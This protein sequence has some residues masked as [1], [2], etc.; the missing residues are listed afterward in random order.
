MI[1]ELVAD[2]GRLNLLHGLA[3][4]R[5]GEVGHADLARQ[6]LLAELDEL[7]QGGR[8]IHSRRGPMDQIEI[9][10]G[11]LQLR[12]RG[13]HGALHGVGG[14]IFPPDLGGQV[15][16]AARHGGGGQRRP[17]AVFIAIHLGGVDVPVAAGQ[18]ALHSRLTLR[19]LQSPGAEPEL[20]HVQPACRDHRVRTHAACSIKAGF[21]EF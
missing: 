21:G 15:N 2:D 1:L 12:E 5:N 9:D 4:Q 3:Q 7:A 8:K 6:P 13:L 10:I 14:E 11:G 20:G 18:R 19:P 17:H 16:I